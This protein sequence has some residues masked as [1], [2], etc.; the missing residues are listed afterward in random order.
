MEVNNKCTKFS[1]DP[2]PWKLAAAKCAEMDGV[3]ATCESATQCEAFENALKDKASGRQP[4]VHSDPFADPLPRFGL[5]LSYLPL[6]ELALYFCFC[7]HG[8]LLKKLNSAMEMEPDL[9]PR[10]NSLFM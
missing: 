9:N 1:T 8:K 4:T 3:L 5:I 10:P 6:L 7:F 2:L